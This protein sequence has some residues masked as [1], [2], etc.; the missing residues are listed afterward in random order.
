MFCSVHSQLFSQIK[1]FSKTQHWKLTLFYR[2]FVWVTFESC[3]MNIFYL[4]YMHTSLPHYSLL[5]PK[6][7]IT[8]WGWVLWNDG[9]ELRDSQL[10]LFTNET[11]IKLSR[12]GY[13]Q[14]FK[15]IYITLKR[16]YK[17][18]FW[19]MVFNFKA[20]NFIFTRLGSD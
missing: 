13:L 18:W 12:V 7:L 9:S 4:H 1:L 14:H 20:S 15:Q 8:L 5:G 10:L 6:T 3:L 11:L 2:L 17:L 19:T 16:Y